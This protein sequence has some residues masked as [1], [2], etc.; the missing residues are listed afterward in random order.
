ME[1][2]NVIEMNR[3]IHEDNSAFLCGNGFSMNF[4]E[5][6]CNI[7]DRLYEAH[8]ELIKNS[9]YETKSNIY[10]SKKCKGNFNNVKQYLRDSSKND[11]YEIFDDGIIFSKYILENELLINA[12]VKNGFTTDLVFG[13]RE[14]NLLEEI[15]TVGITEGAN[16]V[17]MALS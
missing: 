5:D 9:K 1:E 7:F 12:L 16:H 4:D 8:K 15:Y 11:L 3:I 17:N 2:I 10:F 6:F 14:I 13:V